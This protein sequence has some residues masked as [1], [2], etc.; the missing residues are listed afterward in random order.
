MAIQLAKVVTGSRIIAIDIDNDKLR[1]AKDNGADITINS[2]EEDAVKV[3]MESTEKLGADAVIDLVNSSKTAEADMRMLRRRAKVV[4]VGLF[5]GELNLNLIG[6]PT[7]AYR[8]IGS[9]TGS[10]TDMVELV[11][12]A[13]RK[14]IEPVVSDRFKLDQAT[15]ALTKLKEGQIVGRSV[16]NP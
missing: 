16:I 1:I 6:M 2:T 9:Y 7:R 3:V 12:L 13:K 14:V 11:S 5:G 10:M 8:L 4:F 15:E